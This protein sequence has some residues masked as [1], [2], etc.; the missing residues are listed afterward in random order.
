MANKC[1]ICGH[2]ER[3]LIDSLLVEGTPLRNIVERV[4]GSVSVAK[5]SLGA[6]HRHKHNHLLKAK[7]KEKQQD[8]KSRE[9]G[10]SSG[11]DNSRDLDL[12]LELKSLSDRLD[13]LDTLDTFDTK[14]R[15]FLLGFLRLGTVTQAAR[16]VG[17]DR[18]TPYIWKKNDPEFAEI[19][20]V[21]EDLRLE[22]ETEKLELE[23]RRRAKERSD[24]LLEFLLKSY[25]PHRFRDREQLLDHT[26]PISIRFEL[27][28][29]DGRKKEFGMEANPVHPLR[30]AQDSALRKAMETGKG[31]EKEEEEIID[32]DAPSG[33]NSYTN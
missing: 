30:Q 27:I 8:G 9:L 15:A 22:L 23:A 21:I 17:I 3:E 16:S 6:L 18:T 4:S 2:S 7:A 25:K 1:T 32:A 24:R 14:K 11:L 20:D 5:V 13:G 19:F 28:A 29:P 12:E 33:V 31:K 26:R 10:L